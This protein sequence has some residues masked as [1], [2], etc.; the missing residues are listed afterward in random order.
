MYT[1]FGQKQDRR[2]AMRDSAD[3]KILP[4]IVLAVALGLGIPIGILL[5]TRLLPVEVAFPLGL[6]FVA[7]SVFL[8]FAALHE[9][10]KKRTA[11][12]VR[13]PTSAIAQTGVFRVTRNPI[14]LSMMLL[15]VGLSLLVNSPWML[16]LA[17]PTGSALCL[18]AIK[19]EERYLETKFGD[20]Y[21][22]YRAAVPRWIGLRSITN[23]SAAK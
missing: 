6:G 9:L 19:P 4:P 17:I 22:A 20:S 12:D 23:N 5:P 7:F 1:V 13:K 3:V 15:Y 11:F 16:L 14:Y 21:R 18:A 8:V 2:I 10:K